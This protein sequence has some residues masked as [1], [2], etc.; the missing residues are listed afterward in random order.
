MGLP[1]VGS[2]FLAGDMLG[3]RL[4]NYFKYRKPRKL[5]NFV[6]VSGN[7]KYQKQ[8]LAPRQLS[9][10][11]MEEVPRLL[12]GQLHLFIFVAVQRANGSA[13]LI[14]SKKKLHACRGV[15]AE[16]SHGGL[17]I[18]VPSCFSLPFLWCCFG[19]AATSRPVRLRVRL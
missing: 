19:S 4:R 15:G 18:L 8:D 7:T 6:A 12:H 14:K 11:R 5:N 10:Y 16:V 3:R 1:C 9:G 13:R 2:K 17:S